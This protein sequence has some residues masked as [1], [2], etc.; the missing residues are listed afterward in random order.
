[1]DLHD[2]PH[3]PLSTQTGGHPG[4]I[5]TEDGSLIIKPALPLE[6]AFYQSLASES[7]LQPLSDFVPGFLG[8]LRLEGKVDIESLGGDQ[9]GALANMEGV[10]E[11]VG[12]V[13]DE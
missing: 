7:T 3:I 2:T 9:D 1:M 6:I 4:I 12:A 5:T 8:T 10:K 13:K 11:V